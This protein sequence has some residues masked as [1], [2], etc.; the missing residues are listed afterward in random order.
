VSFFRRTPQLTLIVNFDG[1]R[2]GA[3][4]LDISGKTPT[5]RFAAESETAFGETPTPEQLLE[6]LGLKLRSVLARVKDE[7]LVAAAQ[8]SLPAKISRA[9]AFVG[10][11]WLDAAV[12]RLCVSRAK[13]FSF[14]RDSLE[15]IIGRNDFASRHRG[16]LVERAVVHASANGY[17]VDDPVGQRAREFEITVLLAAVAAPIRAAII[18]ALHET[19]PALRISFASQSRAVYEAARALYPSPAT[20]LVLDVGGELI[21]AARLEGDDLAAVGSAPVGISQ[22]VRAIASRCKMELPMAASA[23]RTHSESGAS[24]CEE[25]VAKSVAE[26]AKAWAESVAKSLAQV[27]PGQGP[28]RVAVSAASEH[29]AAARALA[30]AAFPGAEP[31]QIS[32]RA[33]LPQIAADPAAHPTTICS[34]LAV[35]RHASH[36]G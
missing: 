17:P 1:S 4:L 26:A 14:S 6:T 36:R 2:A 28:S 32:Q 31:L 7:G 9:V 29:E 10:A 21:E 35:H 25:G 15:R 12:K 30:I 16:S 8:A 19:F 20:T 11:P 23:L 5:L 33:L 27:A 24:D 18:D 22:A 13:P 3:A 34:A